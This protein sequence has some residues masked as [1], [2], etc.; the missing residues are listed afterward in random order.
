MQRFVGRD[1][2]Y[3]GRNVITTVDPKHAKTQHDRLQKQC[4]LPNCYIYFPLSISVPHVEML[5]KST[6]YKGMQVPKTFIATLRTPV[7]KTEDYPFYGITKEQMRK[8]IG[9]ILEE[10]EIPHRLEVE[11]CRQSDKDKKIFLRD[12]HEL[13]VKL[14][15]NY[16]IVVKILC[17]SQKSAVMAQLALHQRR[18][19][20]CLWNVSLS[21]NIRRAVYV[22]ASV[23]SIIAYL[24]C[25]VKES[26]ASEHNI[27]KIIPVV[28]VD[29]IGHHPKTS[30]VTLK[31]VSADGRR[32]FRDGARV[33]EVMP[34]IIAVGNDTDSKEYFRQVLKELV[35]FV[36]YP[37]KVAGGEQ[38]QKNY[39]FQCS[40]RP[41]V[42]TDRLLVPLTSGGC[43]QGEQSAIIYSVRFMF[44]VF[45][46][47]ILFIFIFAFCLLL[48]CCCFCF[49]LKKSIMRKELQDVFIVDMPQFTNEY[50]E[51]SLKKWREREKEFVQRGKNVPVANKDLNEEQLAFKNRWRWRFENIGDGIC[52]IFIYPGILHGSGHSLRIVF[53][54]TSKLIETSSHE[55]HMMIRNL[56]CFDGYLAGGDICAG[57]ELVYQMLHKLNKTKHDCICNFEIYRV[58]PCF[59]FGLLFFF[60]N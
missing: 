59:C 34:A 6:K 27:N 13:V 24:F 4:E 15:I 38:S 1:F 41:I 57:T 23:E 60:V 20:K 51:E 10:A 53:D 22:K 29:G 44:L 56:S 30:M 19:L 16:R 37:F 8:M 11:F 49:C 32:V 39:L 43:T 14:P 31:F 18:T 26:Q 17:E 9:D 28:H 33:S 55:Y 40:K 12:K 42:I 50:F 2:K 45:I 47:L 58:L 5:T 25:G 21:K 54:I 7:V 36:K 52:P 35:Q 3:N 48:F 46:F